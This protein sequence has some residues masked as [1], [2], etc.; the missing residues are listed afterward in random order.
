MVSKS[1]EEAISTLEL[2]RKQVEPKRK[3]RSESEEAR[4][5]VQRVISQEL[6]ELKGR[7]Y[8]R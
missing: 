7:L 2:L 3:L 5:A 8:I 6:L 1:I 4:G